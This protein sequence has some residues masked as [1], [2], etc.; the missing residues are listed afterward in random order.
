MCWDYDNLEAMG[1]IA[2]DAKCLIDV[3]DTWDPWT[4]NPTSEQVRH[5]VLIV[6][7][8]EVE[9]AVARLVRERGEELVVTDGDDW[10][11]PLEVSTEHP[12]PAAPPLLAV[13][14]V[15]SR[16]ANGEWH[17][18]EISATDARSAVLEHMRTTPTNIVELTVWTEEN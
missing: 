8:D 3:G 13:W 15:E 11:T 7:R 5:M 2:K 14:N 10:S 16:Q 4:L 1:K 18:R 9:D 17:R 6:P 12:R